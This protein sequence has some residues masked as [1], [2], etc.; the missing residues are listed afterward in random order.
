MKKFTR[1]RVV[2]TISASIS[3]ETFGKNPL[4]FVFLA[5]AREKQE[6]TRQALF[7]GIEELIDQVLLDSDIPREH[8]C[9]KAVGK[10]MFGVKDTNHLGFFDYER[11]GWRNGG[12]RTN[13]NR[14][15]GE[16]SFANEIPRPQD[17][18]DR[19]FARFIDDGEPYSTFLNVEDAPARITLRKDRFF[20][21]E[22]R[23]LAGH[24]CRIRNS[25][26]LNSALEAVFARF[27]RFGTT[28][29]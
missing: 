29:S 17:G 19:L 24:T 1:E 11:G 14:L 16:A 3:C 28:V 15:T 6:R 26:V 4:E 2:P 20:F 7:A 12:R 25:R 22:F 27:G 13:P 10:L 9:D 8:E 18:H 5:I 23:D 21:L